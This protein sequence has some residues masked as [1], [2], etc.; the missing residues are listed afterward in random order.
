MNPLT[1]YPITP[2]GCFLGLVLALLPLPLYFQSFNTGIC[3]L[4]FWTALSNLTNLVNTIIWHDN[5]T[6]SVALWCDISAFSL[7]YRNMFH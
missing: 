4:S 5:V 2:I 3:M 6:N 1:P 7:T